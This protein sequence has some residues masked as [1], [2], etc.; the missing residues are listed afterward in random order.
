MSVDLRYWDRDWIARLEE[1]LTE[2]IL[3]Q[4]TWAS[5]VALAQYLDPNYVLRDHLSLLDERLTQAVHDVENGTSRYLVI[6]MPPRLGKSQLISVYLPLWLLHRHPDWQLMLLSHSPD[7]ATGWGRQIR[8]L[9]EEHSAL[10]LSIALDAGAASQW[11]TTETGTVV[12]RSIRQ[13]VTGL[14]AKV[15]LLDDI[16]KDFAD[17]HSKTNRDFVWDWWQANSRTRLHPPSLVVVVAT[18]WHEDDLIGRLLSPEYD[19]NPDQ[20]EEIS[21]PALAEEG[22]AL[23]REVGEPLLSPIIRDETPEE[24][25]VRWADIRQAVGA[26]AW[27][28]L[29]QQRPS[30]ADGAVFL[31]DWW[32]FWRPGDLPEQFDRVLTSWDMAFKGTDTSDYVVGQLWATS[33]ANRYLLKQFR[34]RLSFTESLAAMRRF[35]SEATDLVPE[36][37][38]EH[39]VEDKAN[40][41][42]VIDV[43]KTEIPGLIPVNPTNSKEAR[44][45]AST[46]EIESGNVFLPALAEWLPTFLAEHQAF[47]NGANDDQVDAG[48]QARHRLRSVGTVLPL[49][50]VA[51]INRPGG[52]SRGVG[53]Q[54]SPFGRRRA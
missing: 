11:E 4:Q 5:P 31:S 14:G 6:S 12:S 29:F 19:G 27:A 17:A 41:T 2:S 53:R 8:R 37:V 39:L 16:T 10:G 46:P 3:Q 28:A 40:G 54:T 49:L 45:R 18:R 23:G 15:M 9:V 24:A 52:G 20:W 51:R 1:K 38:H 42:A 36:G 7:L 35:I 22:D 30:P 43:L 50:P 25:L 34:D 26:Y 21:L 32:Q 13:S 48:V 44:A 33:G 47:P